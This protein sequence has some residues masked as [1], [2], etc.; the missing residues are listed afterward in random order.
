[1]S[2]NT[3]MIKKVLAQHLKDKDTPKEWDITGSCDLFKAVAQ[4]EKLSGMV[5]RSYGFT[6]KPG[7]IF[8]KWLWPNDKRAR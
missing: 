6:D 5:A 1:M 8:I 2:E 3:A 7:Q 4:W